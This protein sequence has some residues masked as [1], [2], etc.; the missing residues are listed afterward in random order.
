MLRRGIAGEALKSPATYLGLIAQRESKWLAVTGSGVQIPLGP[1]FMK[2]L[3]YLCLF[4]FATNSFSQQ[5]LEDSNNHLYHEVPPVTKFGETYKR[6]KHGDT[7]YRNHNSYKEWLTPD[8]GLSCCNDY[9]CDITRI[10]HEFDFTTQ[11]DVYYLYFSGQKLILPESKRLREANGTYKK[12]PDMNSHACILE[13]D[14]G[15]DIRCWV[16]GDNLY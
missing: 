4:L 13:N 15:P 10:Y 16:L 5:L 8:T 9:D 11:K 6:N 1:P 12:S 2:I 14:L 3:F 7:H